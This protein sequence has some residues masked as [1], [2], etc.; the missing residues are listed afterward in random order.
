MFETVT[1]NGRVLALIPADRTIPE[2]DAALELAAGSR[3]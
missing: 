1:K 3:R 2:G